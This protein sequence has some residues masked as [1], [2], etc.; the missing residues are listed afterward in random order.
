MAQKARS[1]SRWNETAPHIVFLIQPLS[2]RAT[3]GHFFFLLLKNWKRNDITRT[4]D[5]QR[6]RRER[7]SLAAPF[8]DKKHRVLLFSCPF[9]LPTTLS[10]CLVTDLIKVFRRVDNGAHKTVDKESP[11]PPLKVCSLPSVVLFRQC[12]KRHQNMK[13]WGEN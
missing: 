3:L 2:Y 12:L 4:K 9:T 10:L 13:W 5:G 6:R 8:D 1:V 7:G 11:H